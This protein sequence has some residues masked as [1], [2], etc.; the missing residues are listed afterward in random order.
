MSERGEKGKNIWCNIVRRFS[1]AHIFRRKTSC[2]RSGEFREA[3]A[4]VVQQEVEQ[5]PGMLETGGL[6]LLS[7]LS[8]LLTCASYPVPVDGVR[9]CI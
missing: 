1:V 7:Y 9:K 8:C 4:I 6:C 2:L 3:Q 5:S